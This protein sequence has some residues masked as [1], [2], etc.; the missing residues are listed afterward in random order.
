MSENVSM[1]GV[2]EAFNNITKIL[3]LLSVNGAKEFSEGFPRS[4]TII[5]ETKWF[6]WLDG[7]CDCETEIYGYLNGMKEVIKL[8]DAK[9]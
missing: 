2:G 6:N 5:F 3:P 1:I 9:L 4:S 8:E 7:E